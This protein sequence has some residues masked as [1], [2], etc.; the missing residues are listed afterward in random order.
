MSKQSV[1]DLFSNKTFLVSQSAI[2]WKIS[3]RV[4]QLASQLCDQ[5][6]KPAL[7]WSFASL[8]SEAITILFADN[9]RQTNCN[10]CKKRSRRFSHQTCP[11]K[12]A[13]VG[14]G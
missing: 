14:I 6:E 2:D 3:E 10:R 13:L 12:S 5:L 9:G 11:V 1:I 4:I 8:D 7:I